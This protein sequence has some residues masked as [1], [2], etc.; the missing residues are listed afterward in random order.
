MF[1]KTGF[2]PGEFSELIWD[3]YTF[4]PSDLHIINI[5]SL[6]L[7]RKALRFELEHLLN[8]NFVEPF[9]RGF[10]KPTDH[11]PTEHRP[12]THRPTGHRPTDQPTQYSPEN[13]KL[14][15]LKN[16]NTA[17]KMLSCIRSI[18]Y[19]MNNICLCKFER[20]QKNSRFL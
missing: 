1:G 10:I 3:H 5:L 6:F 17:G 15:I 16:T 4:H 8:M 20:L 7:K 14:S 13:K 19:L 18:I 9:Q 12:L 2:Q 11:R